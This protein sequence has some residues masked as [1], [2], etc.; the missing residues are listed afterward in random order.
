MKDIK[1][2]IIKFFMENP[3]PA[4]KEVHKYAISLGINE[5]KFEEYIYSILGDILA[6]GRSKGFNGEYDPKELSMGIKVEMEHTTSPLI[7]EKIAKD[8]LAELRDYYTRLKKMESEGGVTESTL[9][10][11]A[12]DKIWGKYNNEI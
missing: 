2:K 3:A 12:L 6:G 8:H 10:E 7:A 5:H 4:D 9:H 1:E 11:R